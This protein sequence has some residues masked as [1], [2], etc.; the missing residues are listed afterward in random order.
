M[1]LRSMISAFPNDYDVVFLYLLFLMSYK[2]D[3]ESSRKVNELAI[4]L[5]DL[6]P[7]IYLK[8]I[9]DAHIRSTDEEGSLFHPTSVPPVFK[10]FPFPRLNSPSLTDHDSSQSLNVFRFFEFLYLIFIF[11]K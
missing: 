6:D 7:G 4:R 10:N 11:Y 1:R 9:I 5:R 8:F 2:K 3:N